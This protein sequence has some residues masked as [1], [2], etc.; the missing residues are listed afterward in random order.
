MSLTEGLWRDVE[1]TESIL[2]FRRT[3][4]A[5][6]AAGVPLAAAKRRAISKEES[7][8]SELLYQASVAWHVWKEHLG[9]IAPKVG[10]VIQDDNGVRW[11]AL[12]VE[13]Q[14]MGERYRLACLRER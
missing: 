1:G 10:D 3:G 4:D 8:S 5:V 7:G 6:F 11:T 12:R 9:G 14:S 13:I 2:F